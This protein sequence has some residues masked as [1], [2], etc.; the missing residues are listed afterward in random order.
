MVRSTIAIIGSF[1]LFLALSGRA[2]GG[3]K[4]THEK[5]INTD[6]ALCEA[7]MSPYSTIA[8]IL[9]RVTD[10]QALALLKANYSELLT[11][12]SQ[13]TDATAEG[14]QSKTPGKY[15]VEKNLTPS[16]LLFGSDITEVNRTAVGFL[17]LKWI[18]ADD[19]GSFT[20]NQA[21]P[22]KLKQESFAELRDYVLSVLK[23]PLDVDAMIVMILTNDL[24]KVKR[25]HELAEKAIGRAIVDHDQ[26]LF[27]G[28]NDWPEMSPNFLRLHDKQ[29]SWILNGLNMGAGLNIA[30]FAQAENLPASLAAVKVVAGKP[31]A[32]EFKF[33]EMLLDVAGASGHIDSNGAKVMIEPVFQNFML[34]R[35]ALTQVI[36]GHSLREGYDQ[37]LVAK[38]NL[39]VKLGA[40]SLEVN[41]PRDRALLRLLTLRRTTNLAQSS[42]LIEVFSRLPAN[43]QALLISELNVDGIEDGLGILPYYA[44]ALINNALSKLANVKDG[45]R[46]ALSTTMTAMAR[47]FQLARVGELKGRSGNGVLTINLESLAAYTLTEA[48]AQDPESLLNQEYELFQQNGDENSFGVKLEAH[49]SIARV[50]FKALDSFASL[51]G[52]TVAVLG[53]GGGSDGIQAAQMALMLKAAGKEVKFVGS[54]RT[55]KTASQSANGHIGEARTVQNHGGELIDGVFK[56]LPNSSGS[57]RFLENLPADQVPMYLIVDHQN[58]TLTDRMQTLVN[59]LGGAD[60]L[61]AVDTGGDALYP[62]AANA[63]EPGR[64]TPDQDLRVL[65]AF[66]KLKNS[67]LFSAIVATGVDSPVDAETVLKNAGAKYYSLSKKETEQVLQNYRAWQM[68]GSSDNRYGKTAFAWQLALSGKLGLQTMPLPERVVVDKTNP[69]NPFIIIDDTMGGIFFMQLEGHIKVLSR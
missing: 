56:V 5:I 19:Y 65:Q 22:I 44:P 57:G 21:P 35:R 32:F 11:W 60:L 37:I 69:W 31:E 10:E 47:V 68:D 27:V 1:S 34:A 16:E 9:P 41:R 15:G 43:V 13:K 53:I 6:S 18:L 55:E 2:H 25:F 61:I 39:L 66:S 48:Y 46:L 7:L 8:K 33:V 28:F 20:A 62:V 58:G 50:S 42:E 64:A 29:K 45:S 52:K 40:N 12:L 24:G 17:A 67:T 38:N 59:R 4:S 36:D 3:E 54:V 51:P 26:I 23:T 30:Q 14:S 63:D 49:K